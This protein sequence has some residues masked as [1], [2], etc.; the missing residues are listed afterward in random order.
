MVCYTTPHGGMRYFKRSIQGLV[1]QTEEQDEML[2]RVLHQ[3]LKNGIC[4]KLADDIFDGGTTVDEAID[5]WM[6]E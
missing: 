4:V 6:N 1:G 5:N 2:A 3:E